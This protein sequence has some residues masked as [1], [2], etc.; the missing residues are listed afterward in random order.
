[1]LGINLKAVESS[2]YTQV[3][4]HEIQPGCHDDE[5]TLTFFLKHIEDSSDSYQFKTLYKLT[6]PIQ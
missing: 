3:F 2:W 1:M 4:S 5:M 6:F